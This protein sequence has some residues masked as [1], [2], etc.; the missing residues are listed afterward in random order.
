MMTGVLVWC[1]AYPFIA[2][3]LAYRLILFS[4]TTGIYALLCAWELWR[5]APQRLASQRVAVFLLVLLA[6]LNIMR[7]WLGFSLTSIAWI[8][9]MA[10]RW[11]SEM[12][13]FLVVFAPTLAFIFLSMAK[14]SV[15]LGYKR[16]AFID[17]LTGIPNRR[18]FMQHAAQLLQDVE[19]RAVSCLVF[20]LDRFKSINDGYGHEAGDKVLRAFGQI[21]GEHL[22]PQ[23]FGRLGGE[24]FAAILPM[25]MEDATDLAEAVRSALSKAGK[26]LLGPHAQVTV[27]VGCST[28]RQATI[29]ALL[30]EADLALY[31]AKDHGRNVVISAR[32]LIAPQQI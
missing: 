14:E 25:G 11:S 5:H 21:L 26:T 2:D 12:A 4:L 13:L 17:P 29:E 3:D 18:A 10:Q 8:D 22:P 7:A 20:D 28:S 19:G 9:A 24:E 30:Q 23:S 31:R 32:S 15:E 1:A 27:S 16:A 6:I